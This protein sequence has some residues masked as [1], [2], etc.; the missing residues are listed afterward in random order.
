MCARQ[1]TS[2]N[3]L[4]LPEKTND[5][6]SG[7]AALQPAR[8]QSPHAI[9]QRFAF[10]GLHSGFCTVQGLATTA[11]GNCPIA[12]R[13]PGMLRCVLRNSVR[14]GRNAKPRWFG[15]STR[16]R[17]TIMKS[18]LSKSLLSFVAALLVATSFGTVTVRA[19]GGETGA[20]ASHT[21]PYWSS[22][23]YGAGYYSN[24]YSG[25]Y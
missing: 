5:T 3:N 15:G 6:V 16:R 23:R 21:Q 1:G 19:D 24:W 12:R 13:T 11:R 14:L 20:S 4:N 2:G 17:E 10:R 25:G 8:A 22:S 9:I 7:F 18:L